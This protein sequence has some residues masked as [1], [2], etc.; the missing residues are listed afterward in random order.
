MKDISE[1]IKEISQ[2]QKVTIAKAGEVVMTSREILSFKQIE[3]PPITTLLNLSGNYIA[4][5]AGFS[6]EMRLDTLI[7]DDN[8]IVTFQN[9]PEVHNIRNFSC[10]RSPITSLPN[11]RLLALLAIGDSLETLN[12]SPV[13]RDE[14]ALTS[15]RKLVE[16]F[17]RSNIAKISVSEEQ[18][19]RRVMAESIRKGWIGDQWPKSLDA[20]KNESNQAANDPISVLAVRLFDLIHSDD[21]TILLF[22][23]HHLA[24]AHSV[25]IEP[26]RIDDR[27]EQQQALISFMQDQLN[28][29]KKDHADQVK[30]IQKVSTYKSKAQLA[31]ELKELTKETLEAYNSMVQEIAPELYEN[32][33]QIRQEEEKKGRKNIKGLRAIVAKILDVDPNIGDRNLA[34][35]LREYGKNAI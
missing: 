35:M 11:F 14:R 26:P 3:I 34:K 33:E 16:L 13:T 31:D 9:F 4:E 24:P 25:R 30:R 27:L 5:F 17:K 10:L 29:L 23:K 6:P 19:A 21:E 18:E 32:S 12:G 1:K 28:E 8:P 7:L 22:F 20:V 15:G 2:Q